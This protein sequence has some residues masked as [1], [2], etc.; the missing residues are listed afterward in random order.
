MNIIRL[1]LIGGLVYFA[2]QQKKEGTKNMILIV[3]GLLAV[4]M[5]SKEGFT[6]G[7]EHQEGTVTCVNNL[8]DENGICSDSAI[9][10]RSDCEATITC[11]PPQTDDAIVLQTFT[12][13][14]GSTLTDRDACTTVGG[15]PT[16]VNTWTST[17]CGAATSGACTE[18]GCVAEQEI[19]YTLSEV[20]N[21]VN[22]GNTAITASDESIYTYTGQGNIV[23]TS[24]DELAG[25]FTCNGEATTVKSTA[26]ESDINFDGST[27][28]DIENLLECSTATP[29]PP[30]SSPAS[31]IA[32]PDLTPAS[33]PSATPSPPGSDDLFD[34]SA[35][36]DSLTSWWG[37]FET[38]QQILIISAPLALMGFALYAKSKKK[39]AAAR[40]AQMAAL[41]DP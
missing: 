5:L 6:I 21:N 23:I 12:G 20:F 7:S 3:T 38:W 31:V 18:D 36:W 11:A 15:I 30:S 25:A 39:S 4:C 19:T 1:L 41:A 22:A 13:G 10:T 34:F 37:E 35:E 28:L 26:S 33:T 40:A 17:N 14:Q 27:K 32:P 24:L 29:P 16:S 2:M 9:N 8:P